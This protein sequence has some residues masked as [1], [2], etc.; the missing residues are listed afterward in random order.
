MENRAHPLQT[1]NGSV[2]VQL[3]GI[4]LC[5]LQAILEDEHLT[6]TTMAAGPS[7]SE[8]DS[9]PN[10]CPEEEHLV[11]WQA[12]PLAPGPA[13]PDEGEDVA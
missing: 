13:P 6:K 5:V 1:F 10:K 3:L 11:F 9:R 8:A 12:A 4:G 2:G 7:P